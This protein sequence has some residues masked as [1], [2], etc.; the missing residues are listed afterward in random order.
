MTININNGILNSTSV[1]TVVLYEFN[2]IPRPISP[3]G[4]LAPAVD[5][6]STPNLLYSTGRLMAQYNTH[7]PSGVPAGT[8][9][10]YDPGSSNLDQQVCSGIITEEWINGAT[11]TDF[12]NATTTTNTIVSCQITPLLISGS[13]NAG[14]NPNVYMYLLPITSANN[15]T[16]MTAFRA[17]FNVSVVATVNYQGIPTNIITLT[18]VA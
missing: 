13:L 9:V 4:I 7:A 1:Q 14:A 11:G 2:G 18:G 17:A 15:A 10:N 5:T 12:T 16:V 8:W 3:T 6:F